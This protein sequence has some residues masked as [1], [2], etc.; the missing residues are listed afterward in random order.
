[1]AN[2]YDKGAK[3]VLVLNKPLNSYL[4]SSAFLRVTMVA[5]LVLTRF[6]E[7]QSN[8]IH[9]YHDHAD[10]FEPCAKRVKE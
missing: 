4:Q 6:I 2:L 10:S 5:V 1:M 7:S 3:E 9:K 8:A